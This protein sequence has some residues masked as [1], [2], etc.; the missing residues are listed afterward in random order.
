MVELCLVGNELGQCFVHCVNMFQPSS[1]YFKRFLLKMSDRAWWWSCQVVNRVMVRCQRTLKKE[2]N[3]HKTLICPSHVSFWS[4]YCEDIKCVIIS[5]SQ[6]CGFMLT[7]TWQVTF[8]MAYTKSISRTLMS[9]F[10][11]HDPLIWGI[12]VFVHH[13]NGSDCQVHDCVNSVHCDQCAILYMYEMNAH[14]TLVQICMDIWRACFQN[15][16]HPLRHV[17]HLHYW[18]PFAIKIVQVS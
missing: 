11:W 2:G 6:C 12:L 18:L 4:M 8:S 16:L 10:S 17:T 1:N 7:L 14:E 3:P 15:L 9:F 13:Q 5:N